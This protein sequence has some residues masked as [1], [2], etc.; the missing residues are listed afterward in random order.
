MPN[1]RDQNSRKSMI[2][3]PRELVRRCASEL[4]HLPGWQRHPFTSLKKLIYG[5]NSLFANHG[6][7]LY[8]HGFPHPAVIIRELERFQSLCRTA[9][10]IGTCAPV[11]RRLDALRECGSD[12]YSLL[13]FQAAL[14]LDPQMPA[15]AAPDDRTK[16]YLEELVGSQPIIVAAMTENALT[17]LRPLVTPG[18]G[19]D[20]HGGALVKRELVLDL[21][22]IFERVAGRSPGI[23]Y[24]DTAEGNDRY[25]GPFVEF[26]RIV[27]QGLGYRINGRQVYFL[28]QGLEEWAAVPGR[29]RLWG[30]SATD[31]Q[32]KRRA[33]VAH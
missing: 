13:I 18:R 20:R 19:G 32:V 29:R 11:L 6:L 14:D 9:A 10:E 2:H 30:I 26:V 27:F 8:G 21:G 7:V 17:G 4:S 15:R 31:D 28:Y 16:R 33:S 23:T 12:S 25:T 24:D 5:L 1:S 3:V 22:F